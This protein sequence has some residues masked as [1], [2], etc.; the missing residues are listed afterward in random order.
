MKAFMTITAINAFCALCA[1]F[2]TLRNDRQK[3]SPH[4]TSDL[5][6][7]GKCFVKFK[8]VFF[9]ICLVIMNVL[10][11]IVSIIVFLSLSNKTKFL[12]SSYEAYFILVIFI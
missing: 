11:P 10:T 3:A 7:T 12:E 6:S 1:N 5:Y 8:R 9:V 4:D 2:M